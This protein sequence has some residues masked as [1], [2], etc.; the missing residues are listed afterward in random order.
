MVNNF[1]VDWVD[2]C[3]NWANTPL[4]IIVGK[5]P[6]MNLAT[7]KKPLFIK[8]AIICDV[9]LGSNCHICKGKARSL[10]PHYLIDICKSN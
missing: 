9:V 4:F 1:P 6:T 10:L 8:V 3:I 2:L 5:F 7:Y